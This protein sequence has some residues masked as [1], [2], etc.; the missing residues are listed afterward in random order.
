[1]HHAYPRECA[2]PHL[3]GTTNPVTAE[4]YMDQTGKEIII[5]KDEI[6]DVISKVSAQQQP[7]AD[8]ELPWSGTKELFIYRPEVPQPAG[9]WSL[10]GVFAFAGVMSSAA[11]QRHGWFV[12]GLDTAVRTWKVPVTAARK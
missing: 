4:A 8:G 1:M 2:Y 11:L 10:G 12:N 5:T 6:L 9:T 7:E 3:S